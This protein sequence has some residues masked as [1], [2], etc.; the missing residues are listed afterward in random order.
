MDIG[1]NHLWAE[2]FPGANVAG[3]FRN[4]DEIGGLGLNEQGEQ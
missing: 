4:G 2:N 1:R 3:G